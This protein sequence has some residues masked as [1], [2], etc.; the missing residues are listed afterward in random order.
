MKKL[1]ETWVAAQNVDVESA[2]YE[3]VSWAIDE[4][5][6]LAIEDPEKLL[7]VITE[8]L[9]IDSSQ[10]TLGAIGAGALEDLL[11]HNGDDYIDKLVYLS[12]SNADFQ[13]CLSFTF[14]DENDV[15]KNVYAKFCNI[16]Q[17]GKS[18]TPT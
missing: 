3:S 16:K 12:E 9:K 4:M 13:K 7:L 8:I 11:V 18:G 6:D 15:S 14:I 2:D 5:Y 10:R 17:L 1:I